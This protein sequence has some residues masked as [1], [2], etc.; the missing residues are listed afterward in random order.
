MNTRVEIAGEKMSL[1]SE[2]GTTIARNEQ[3]RHFVRSR[4][5][6]VRIT[7]KR[8]ERRSVFEYFV[9]IFWVRSTEM[10]LTNTTK[11]FL[12]NILVVESRVF[13]KLC[14]FQKPN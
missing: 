1:R 8:V 7:E 13:E 9:N 14:H 5:K 4:S 12:L 2:V 3:K 6:L 10:T 11:I